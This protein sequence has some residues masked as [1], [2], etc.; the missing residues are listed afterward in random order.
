MSKR[1]KQENTVPC[2]ADFKQTAP[3]G[4]GN[5]GSGPALRPDGTPNV[6]NQYG[7]LP[8]GANGYESVTPEE[9]PG[10]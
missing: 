3:R 10:T 4:Q 7:N 5:Y 6:E 1:V 2:D 9:T 8:Q